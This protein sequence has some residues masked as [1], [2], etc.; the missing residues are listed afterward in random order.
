MSDKIV[1]PWKTQPLCEWRIVGMNHYTG[2]QGDYCIYVAMVKDGKC[3]T[4]SG[5]DRESLW[6]KLILLAKGE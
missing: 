2:F 3:I 4:A 5:V 1:L 6:N